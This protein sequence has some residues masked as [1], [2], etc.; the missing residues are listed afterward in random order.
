MIGRTV[1]ST[2]IVS[3]PGGGKTTFLRDLIRCISEKGLR[4]S[5]VDERRELSGMS[6]GKAILNLGPTT[7]V[8]CGAPKVQAIPLLIRAMN[9]Q[10]LAL[11]EIQGE[12]ELEA[13]LYASFSGVAL[14]ATAHGDGRKSLYHRPMYRR[15]LESGAFE[16]CINLDGQKQPMM[17]RLMKHDEMDGSNFCNGGLAD[18]RLGRKAIVEPKI[19]ASAAASA[20]TGTDAGRTGA[21]YAAPFRI[22]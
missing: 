4:V 11:D 13:A 19:A 18:G 14:I 3:P 20:G 21:E 12:K 5:V 2:L 6:E 22:V 16:W 7:D 17:E 10:V 9:P 8:L 15:M 1:S